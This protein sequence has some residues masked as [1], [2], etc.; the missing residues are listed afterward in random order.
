MERGYVKLWR[1]CLDSG[2]IQ[3]GPAWQLFG[4]LLL[5]TTH[6]PHRQIVGGMVFNLQ[7]GEVVFGRVKAA[8]DLGLSE[9]QVR[10][11]FD[12]LKKLEIVASR[13]TNR[14]TVVSF[15]N[16]HRYQDESPAEGQPEGQ[17]QGQQRASRGP[18][19]GQQRATNKNV[20]TKKEEYINTLPL[21]PS[22]EGEADLCDEHTPPTESQSSSRGA[23]ND[24]TKPRAA[25]TNP[26]TN[27][28]SPRSTGDNPRTREPA[29]SRAGGNS[30][31]DLKAF[32]D[33]YTQCPELRQALEDFRVMRE[34]LRKPLTARALQLTCTELDKLAGND[35]VLKTKILDQSIQRGW[36]GIFPLRED[37]KPKVD[38]WAGAI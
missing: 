9:K 24:G 13:S 29:G 10:T 18:A 30:A 26:R 31:A 37:S 7:P 28:T 6:R 3:N 25:G 35:D 32:A 17:P 21:T 22:S 34:R 19:E 12:L 11:A 14:C 4:Y 36:Q 2:L 5:K 8:A 1:K 20:R 38:Q 15:V 33:E 27:G 23:R 16:W